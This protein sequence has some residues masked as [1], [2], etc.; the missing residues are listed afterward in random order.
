MSLHTPALQQTRLPPGPAQPIHAGNAELVSPGPTAVLQE[1]AR[2]E[3]AAAA[4]EE[5]VTILLSTACRPVLWCTGRSA[6]GAGAGRAGHQ[7]VVQCG[8]RL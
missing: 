8:V 7:Q 5:E 4:W 6:G 3:V 1:R 2:A